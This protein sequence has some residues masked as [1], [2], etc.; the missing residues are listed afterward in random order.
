MTA[1]I[2]LTATIQGFLIGIGLI[3]KKAKNRHSNIYLSV[4][5]VL[6]SLELLF[7]WGSLS[8][9]NNSKDRVPFWLLDT[10]LVIPP[11]LWLFFKHNSE[12]N[13]KYCP[14]HLFYFFPAFLQIVISSVAYFSDGKYL[15]F[16]ESVPL[17]WTAF[18]D[19]LPLLLTV[20]VLVFQA[21]KT[22][23]IYKHYNQNTNQV[24]R[25]HSLKLI[26]IFALF[27][28]LGIIWIAE[29]II[30]LDLRWFLEFY[31]VVILFGLAYISFFNSSFFE[32]PKYFQ[33]TKSDEFKSYDDEKEFA[34]LNVLFTN[35]TIFTKPK[36][37][38][39]DLSDEMNLP[40]KYISYLINTYT[41]SNFNDFINSFRVKEVLRKIPIEKN[42]TLLGIAMDAGFNSKSTFN[43]AFK[44]H[45]GKSPSE[46]LK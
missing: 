37:S 32:I 23:E 43:Q 11:A 35:D 39:K 27:C 2:I 38:L 28:I 20:L 14:K 26:I 25:S 33:N 4:L 7:S 34:K 5:I 24:L 10:Y 18:T 42:K 21:I 40:S 46:Y 30:H 15:F 3:F 12:I 31:A 29:S 22:I 9:Y 45:T 44:H 6:F 19:W 36:L 1:T 17:L 41:S 8:G 16:A 13:Y